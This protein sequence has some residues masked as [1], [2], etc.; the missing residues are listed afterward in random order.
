MIHG[1]W[2]KYRISLNTTVVP[3]QQLWTGLEFREDVECDVVKAGNNE[4]YEATIKLPHYSQVCC[5]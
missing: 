3:N 4:Y 1:V 2:R 5:Y